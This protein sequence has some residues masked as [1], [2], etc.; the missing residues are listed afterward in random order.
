MLDYDVWPVADSCLFT[1][2]IMKTVCCEDGKISSSIPLI[3]HS[4]TGGLGAI[5]CARKE[6]NDSTAIGRS[7][8]GGVAATFKRERKR[9][10]HTS[11]ISQVLQFTVNAQ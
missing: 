7:Y 2:K 11:G 3:K 5:I 6:T 4:S 9:V 1:C 10:C 8:L